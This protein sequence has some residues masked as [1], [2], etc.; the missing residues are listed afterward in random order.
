MG[1]GDL[2]LG[3]GERGRVWGGVLEE[4][5]GEEGEGEEGEEGEDFAGLR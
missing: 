3:M 4:E 2:V 5:R 1:A